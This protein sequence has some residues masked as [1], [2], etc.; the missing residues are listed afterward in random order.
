MDIICSYTKEELRLL[1]RC[2]QRKENLL[3][4]RGT[5]KMEQTHSEVMSSPITAAFKLKLDKPLVRK[6]VRKIAA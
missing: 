2:Q 1:G 4:L 6:T 5:H 3:C